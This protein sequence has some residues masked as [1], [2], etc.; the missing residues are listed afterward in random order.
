MPQSRILEKATA[1][2][3]LALFDA[4]GEGVAFHQVIRSE[5]GCPKDYLILEVNAAYEKMTGLKR[6]SVVGRTSL[7]AYGVSEPPYLSEY[8]R[9]VQSKISYRFETFFPPLARHFEISVVPI[10]NNE[11]A[12]IFTDITA[13]KA[14]EE[15]L[16]LS[17]EVLKQIP[18]AI[19]VTDLDGTI[20]RWEGKAEQM[21]G[22][23]VEEAVGKPV[24]FLHHP[25]VRSGMSAE[26]IRQI[27]ENGRFFDEIPCVAKDGS[28]LAIE[29]AAHALCDKDGQAVALVGVSRDVTDR[30]RAEAALRASEAA[31]STIFHSS[32]DNVVITRTADNVILDVNETF[33]RTLGY[34]RE[35]V[36]GK[37]SLELQIWMDPAERARCLGLLAAQPCPPFEA[38]F[39]AK[40]GRSIPVVTSTRPVEI[41]GTACWLSTVRDITER[42]RAEREKARLEDQLR[43]AQ[44]LESI[45]Q[46]A[47]GIAHDFNNLLTV[48][49]G[50]GDLLLAQLSQNDPVREPIAQIRNAGERA[51][52][53]TQQLLA[54][55]RRQIIEPKPLN[56]NTV[57]AA[58]WEMLRRLVGED[59]EL[60][61]SLGQELG[62]VVADAGQIHQVLINLIVN[63]RD[64]LPGGGRVTIETSNEELTAKDQQCNP[65]V[66][67]GSHVCL[68][69]TD[70]G[71][72][73]DENVRQRIF[74]PF[75]TT[76]AD[77][78]GTGLGLATTYGIVRQSGGCV[79]VE[80]APGKGSQFA[81]YLPRLAGNVE[82]EAEEVCDRPDL[83]G[84]EVVLVVE[85]ETEVRKLTVAILRRLG[86]RVLEA[87]GGREAL[88]LASAESGP[89]HLLITDVVMPRMTGREL[90]ERLL[91]FRPDTRVLYMSGYT[92]DVI[93]HRGIL[94][95]GVKYIAKPFRPQELAARVRDLLGPF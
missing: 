74:E 3:Y 26:I 57:I 43:Q 87:P 71:I 48:I 34:R 37:T 44:K 67:P 41:R 60:T 25:D 68:A 95:P 16:R 84:C 66:T 32:P 40:D 11:F 20:Q 28:E 39:R 53:L 73:M 4:M 2:R 55:S 61:A 77:R 22:Y 88:A 92:E 62:L 69:I 6:E 33:L 14:L 21:F 94:D 23:T 15:T 18:D 46:L 54:F 19:L 78:S 17:D 31:L 59:I 7:E 82:S 8:A 64:A 63:A 79:R 52:S 75:F 36:V 86:Y 35:E 24:S 81:V 13:R 65:D 10:G 76:K 45:G 70:T 38:T 1:E 90:A 50:Y 72:G 12:T 91:A 29:T 93:A 47:G 5:S 9:T 49:N 42:L 58:S 30:K 80:S 56:M 51:A 89:I 85:D 83:R 27:H